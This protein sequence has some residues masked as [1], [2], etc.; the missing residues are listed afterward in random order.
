MSSALEDLKVGAGVKVTPVTTSE[1]A[2]TAIAFLRRT[3]KIINK[4]K[5]KYL[6]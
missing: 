1:P 6:V 3:K 4:K 2:T 5:I